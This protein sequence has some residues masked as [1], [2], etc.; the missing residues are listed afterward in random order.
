MTRKR[1]TLSGL[2][3]T[4]LINIMRECAGDNEGIDFRSDILDV[5]FD[6][7]GYDSIALLE[8]AGYI[9]REYGVHLADDVLTTARTPRELLSLVNDAIG[10]SV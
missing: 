2:T 8:T 7:L 10:G 9:Q 6:A 3:L 1:T 4:S 5:D